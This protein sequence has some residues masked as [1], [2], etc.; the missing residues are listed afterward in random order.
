[1][2]LTTVIKEGAWGHI[3][4]HLPSHSL[5]L[6]IWSPIS[7]KMF[8]LGQ[9]IIK[10]ELNRRPLLFEGTTPYYFGMSWRPNLDV[11]KE[12]KIGKLVQ[13]PKWGS[14]IQFGPA[15]KGSLI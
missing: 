10:R 12:S 6:V 5:P 4:L 15:H 3:P 1:L 14:L 8:F 11:W 13:P 2:C 7:S 9:F